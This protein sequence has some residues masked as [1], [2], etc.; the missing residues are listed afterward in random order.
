[1]KVPPPILTQLHSE[2]PKLCAILAF[3]SAIWLKE[4]YEI[5]NCFFFLCF[6]YLLFLFVMKCSFN[7]CRFVYCFAQ[8]EIT[9]NTQSFCL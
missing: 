7:I 6:I 2:K 8:K 4:L 3:L 9:T 1:M 5:S